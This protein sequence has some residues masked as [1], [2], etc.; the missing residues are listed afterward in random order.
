MIKDQEYLKSKASYCLDFAKK[1]GAT[2]ACITI[3]NVITE[4]VGN[5]VLLSWEGGLCADELTPWQIEDGYHDIYRR[6]ES[7]TWEP[8]ACETGVPEE[9]GYE[10]IA[11]LQDLSN[12]SYV[13]DDLLSYG[14]TYCYRIVMRFEDGS[15]SLSSEDDESGWDALE[16]SL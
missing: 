1:L 3:G 9:L 11:S 2:D 12:N 8:T 14:A 10:L 4:T 15:E 16:P 5:T 13:D 6:H 7:Q